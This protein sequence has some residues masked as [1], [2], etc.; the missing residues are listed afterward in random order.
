M[1]VALREGDTLSGYRGKWQSDMSGW[2]RGR[3]TPLKKDF[4]VKKGRGNA[5]YAAWSYCREEKR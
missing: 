1:D 2:F 4:R 5:V 3:W